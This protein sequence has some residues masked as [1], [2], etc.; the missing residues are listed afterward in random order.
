MHN[1]AHPFSMILQ[2][3]RYTSVKKKTRF[4]GRLPE[5]Q[6]KTVRKQLV[7]NLC[8]KCR[9]KMNNFAAVDN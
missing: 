4:F 8:K 6:E 3:I 1:S 7:H 5:P 2:K 9:E